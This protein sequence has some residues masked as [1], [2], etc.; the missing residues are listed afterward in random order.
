MNRDFG[1]IIDS[2]KK[3]AETRCILD[4]ILDDID[5]YMDGDYFTG[6]SHDDFNRGETCG[7]VALSRELLDSLLV[8]YNIAED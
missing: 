7:R 3:E 8:P 1:D 4:D 6:N 5:G 2:L